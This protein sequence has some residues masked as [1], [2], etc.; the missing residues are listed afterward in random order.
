VP[1]TSAQPTRLRR[2]PNARNGTRSDIR[3]VIDSYFG[4]ID[5]ARLRFGEWPPSLSDVEGDPASE[6]FSWLEPELEPDD[7]WWGV[8]T[9]RPDRGLVGERWLEGRGVSKKLTVDSLGFTGG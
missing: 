8:R 2:E 7:G 3:S 1:I 9:N 4:W 5:S 6:S